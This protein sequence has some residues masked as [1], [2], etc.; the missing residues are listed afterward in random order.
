VSECVSIAQ[1]SGRSAGRW[2]RELSS[3]KQRAASSSHRCGC[4]VAA[5]RC[6]VALRCGVAVLR[7]RGVALRR[8]GFV[9]VVV[10]G[11]GGVRGWMEGRKDGR[12]Y[13]TT[14]LPI[15]LAD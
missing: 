8:R 14:P 12:F 3:S 10:G 1:R 4:G 7:R 5:L 15:G 13:H 11:G 9:V 6:V 2:L